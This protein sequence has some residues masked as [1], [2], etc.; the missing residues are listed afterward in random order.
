MEQGGYKVGELG[1][2]VGVQ[3]EADRERNRNRDEVRGKGTEG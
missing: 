1:E 2:E 3:L